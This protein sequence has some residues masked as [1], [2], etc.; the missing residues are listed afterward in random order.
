MDRAAG[1]AGTRKETA[2]PGSEAEDAPPA[3]TMGTTA[4]VSRRSRSSSAK[5]N[6]A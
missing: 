4:S 1:M 2:Q 3:E 5:W 6:P